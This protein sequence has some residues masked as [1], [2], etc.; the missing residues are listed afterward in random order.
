MFTEMP[1]AWTVVVVPSLTETGT[2]K[3]V[4]SSIVVLP[5]LIG[6]PRVTV[7]APVLSMVTVISGR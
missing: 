1:L 6:P 7:H 3:F 2:M 4:K 5:C